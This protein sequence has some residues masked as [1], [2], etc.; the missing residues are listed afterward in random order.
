MEWETAA[1]LALAAI[2]VVVGIVGTVAP[3]MPGAV[4]VL[5]GLALAAWAEGFVYV[6]PGALAGL[7][8]LTVLTYVVD[9]A[10]TALGAKKLGA[11][12]R[13]GVGAALGA[14]VGLFFG[15]P[16]VIIG[17]FAGAVLAELT[18]QSTLEQ[19]GRAGLGAWI[20]LVF[21]TAAK[22]ALVFT[23]IGIFLALRLFA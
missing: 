4:I 14:L 1:W 9:F 19:A 21:G 3:A 5:A 13:A 2:V 11:S 20:G 16:G 22:L 12:R 10:A 8:A 23:M 18:A 6:G 15:I 7:A 17:P